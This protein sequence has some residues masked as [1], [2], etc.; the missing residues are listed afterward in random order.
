M[1]KHFFEKIPVLPILA[2]TFQIDQFGP[3]FPKWRFSAFFSEKNFPNTLEKNPVLAIL[4]K[5]CPKFAIWLDAGFWQ[6]AGIAG[7]PGKTQK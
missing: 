1:F 6:D 4:A 2:K 7:N 3:K 5:N